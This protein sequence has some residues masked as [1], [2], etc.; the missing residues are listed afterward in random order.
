M[1]IHKPMGKTWL[2]ENKFVYRMFFIFSIFTINQQ[3]IQ[4]ADKQFKDKSSPVLG[5]RN[6]NGVQM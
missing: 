2:Q 5:N 1:K 3:D 6:T 4:F